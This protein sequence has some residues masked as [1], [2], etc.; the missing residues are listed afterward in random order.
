MPMSTRVSAY[1]RTCTGR[2]SPRR[3]TFSE[4]RAGGGAVA[5]R[6]VRMRDRNRRQGRP[7]GVAMRWGF[8]L[9]L[10]AAP[11]PEAAGYRVAP[12]LWSTAH[13]ARSRVPGGALT[14]ERRHRAARAARCSGRTLPGSRSPSSTFAPAS[15]I[16]CPAVSPGRVRAAFG[17]ARRNLGDR[18]A[19]AGEDGIKAAVNFASQSRISG[20]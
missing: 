13:C 15:R 10:T 3:T 11:V 1:T 18:D 8:A 7:T 12:A 17:A 4:L 2:Y 5:T 14:S 16:R 20:G 19:L 6:F 9:P